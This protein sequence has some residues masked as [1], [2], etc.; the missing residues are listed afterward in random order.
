[1]YNKGLHNPVWITEIIYLF[2]PYQHTY[3]SSNSFYNLNAE[4]NKERSKESLPTLHHISKQR[5]QVAGESKNV[6]IKK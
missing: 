5:L 4:I 6:V 3:K 1:M 2:H